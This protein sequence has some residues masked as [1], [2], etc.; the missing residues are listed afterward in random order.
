MMTESELSIINT[1]IKPHTQ[2][3][4]FES[5]QEQEQQNQQ[6]QN[7]QQTMV[8]DE[9]WVDKYRPRTITDLVGNEDNMKAIRDWF[10]SYKNRDPKIKRALLLVGSPGT[11]KSSSVKVIA[12]EEGFKTMEFNA[13]DCRNKK[14]IQTIVCESSRSTN[15]SKMFGGNYVPHVIVMD[16]VDGMSRGDRGG[17]KEL[18]KVINPLKEKRVLE[19]KKKDEIKGHWFAPIICIANTD[20]LSKLKNL[21]TQCQMLTFDIIGNAD[22]QK[23]FDRVT[24]EEHIKFED[25]RVVNLILDFAQGDC[26]RLLNTLE[27]ISRKSKPIY[28][29]Y[30]VLSVLNMFE[31]KKRDI[32]IHETIEL[33]IDEN[34][35]DIGKINQIFNMDR[36]LVPLMVQ[37]N[38]LRLNFQINENDQ[39]KVDEL[40]GMVAECSDL[41]SLSDTIS[42]LIFQLPVWSLYPLFGV[43]CVYCPLLLLKQIE[44]TK[45]KEFQY[46][47]HLGCVSTNSAQ[48]KILSSIG[49]FN[50]RF[51]DRKNI[52]ILK[53]YLFH[54]IEDNDID[55]LIKTLYNYE[56]IPSVL[57]IILRVQEIGGDN[58]EDIYKKFKK[59]INAKFRNNLDEKFKEYEDKM[60][61]EKGQIPIADR[62]DTRR[63]LSFVW[64]KKKD[65]YI[66][67][68]IK[69]NQY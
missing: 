57:D 40:L 20:H 45:P 54:L 30:D 23:L 64:D 59:L 48:K 34:I 24:G 61:K 6:Q 26:R 66:P 9:M 11:G 14:S 28:N 35:D 50:P 22:L 65:C 68:Q 27:M 18:I 37:E 7:Q 4:Q 43:M 36:S 39:N 1:Q 60:Y 8:S 44:F 38:Y 21:I 69:I 42:F 16:E 46:T 47:Q 5:S 52:M 49:E 10:R 56:M 62:Y 63:E 31:V 19:K 67:E 29:Q 13:S 58:K 15:I 3:A 2:T 41:I 33:L 12:E 17:L 32:S 53:E 55:G 25:D 51:S